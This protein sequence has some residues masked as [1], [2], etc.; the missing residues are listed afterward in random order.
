[1]RGN[2]PIR[3]HSRMPQ[4]SHQNPETLRNTHTTIQ[5]RSRRTKTILLRQRMQT[6]R[7]PN[8][9]PETTSMKKCDWGTTNPEILN[10]CRNPATWTIISGCTALHIKTRHLCTRHADEYHN[11]IRTLTLICTRCGGTQPVADYLS[12]KTLQ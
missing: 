5:T 10:F 11:K 8:H 3:H 6:T 1:M 7:R 2:S 4:L 12:M 9:H